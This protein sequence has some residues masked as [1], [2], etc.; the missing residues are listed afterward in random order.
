MIEIKNLTK[1]FKDSTRKVI[2]V[3]NL[4]MSLRQGE[5][6]GL[7]GP[8]G[9]GKTTTI[10]MIS[11]LLTP[12]SGDIFVKGLSVWTQ[13]VDVRKLIG[14]VF[15]QKLIY[16]RLSGRDN[17]RFYGGIYSVPD[18]DS[19]IDELADMFDLTHVLDSIVETYSTGMVCKL[20]LARGLIHNPDVLLL[21]EPTV[22]LDPHVAIR[23]RERIK[24]LK[25]DDKTILLTTHNMSEAEELCDRIGILFQGKLLTIDTTKNLKDMMDVK[26]KLNIVFD[27]SDIDKASKIFDEIDGCKGSLKIKDYHDLGE[28]I[29]IIEQSKIK[30]KEC[31]I[32]ATTLEDVF[33]HFSKD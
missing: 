7:L 25:E 13:G 22:G 2:A 21:D 8:N 32:K 5:I 29:K 19:R 26:Q 15:G 27:I 23:L 14:S 24:R 16:R 1:E 20:A 30:V 12:T 28:K 10:K 11:T 4:N 3:S 9:S 6:F 33:V 31:N 17:L 18:L